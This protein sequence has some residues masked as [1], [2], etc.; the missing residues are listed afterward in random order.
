VLPPSWHSSKRACSSCIRFGVIGTMRCS[1]PAWCS[2]SGLRTVSRP[3]SQSTS[4]QQSWCDSDGM[5][6]PAW[7]ASP[8]SSFHSAPGQASMTLAISPGVTCRPYQ[9]TRRTGSHGRSQAESN[10]ISPQQFLT[11]P[12]RQGSAHSPRAL[13]SVLLGHRRLGSLSQQVLTGPRLQCLGEVLPRAA[14]VFAVRIPSRRRIGKHDDVNRDHVLG[15]VRVDGRRAAR[16][17]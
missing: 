15:I 4:A 11:N 12:C 16:A 5:R 2:V 6:R 3:R 14:L 9:L 8:N 13:F 1:W 17:R 10:P 7:R